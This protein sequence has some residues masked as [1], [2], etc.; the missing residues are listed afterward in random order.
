MAPKRPN[1]LIFNPDE[2]RGDLLGHLG[3]P[4]AHTPHLDALVERDG[5]VSFRW[6][7]CQNPV[8]TPS[9]CSYLTGW[10]P[11]TRGHRT[12]H[13]LLHGD[14]G[15]PNLL[16]VL[17]EAGYHVW[18]AGKNDVL[19]SPGDL[20]ASLSTR[21]QPTEAD[22]AR[23][24]YH[25][26]PGI[27]AFEGL[28]RGPPDGEDYYSFFAGELEPEND[29]DVWFDAD[30]ACVCAAREYIQDWARQANK[31]DATPP[32]C[33]YL[34]LRHPHPPY[35]VERQWRARIDPDALPERV[36][37]PM[38]PN[39]QPWHA[40]PAILRAIWERQHL[41]GWTEAQWTEL[42]ATYYGMCARVDHL[43]GLLVQTL[44]ET[45]TLDD[46][47]VLFFADHGDFAGDY[48]LVEKNQNT[49]EDC[50]CRV[51]LVVKPPRGSGAPVPGHV[52]EALVELV[53]VSATIY[54]L[55]DLAPPYTYFGRSLV[56]TMR[57]RRPD[58][59]TAVFCEGGR[60]AGEEH[61]MERESTSSNRPSG[62][63]WPRVGLQV[64]PI[65][66]AAPYHTKATMV[67]TREYK[68]VYRLYETDEL[69]D[70]RQD[71]YELHNEITNPN[72]AA[73]LAELKDQMLRWF[74]TTG[75]VVPWTTDQRDYRG[76]PGDDS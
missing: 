21:Y 23:W 67:R 2:W 45:G 50:L 24:G 72:Y 4:A 14:H 16:R 10:Y 48:G 66:P 56:E 70:L 26:Y 25:L 60:L 29:D 36:P 44:K 33:M 41:S 35:G 40:K 34:P 58:H 71:P 62:Q 59:R 1:V 42:R 5:A 15:E 6:A 3:N 61:C 43:F 68:Y 76:A 52:N 27:A 53:D 31:D 47:L 54:D 22:C 9:R 7:F 11:H 8:C 39:E 37:T 51:P 18:M 46:T 13:H 30:H 65:T 57:A 73:V 69:Y 20:R 28:W 38:G 74:V 75:D 32:F 63:Y 12:M 19:G 17:K 49:F 64:Q 55:L